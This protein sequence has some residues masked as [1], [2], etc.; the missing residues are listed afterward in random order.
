M[1]LK[2][3]GLLML[4]FKGEMVIMRIDEKFS[5]VFGNYWG[6]EGSI[7]ASVNAIGT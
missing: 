7:Y 3:E 5:I 2:S 4:F 1:M 6:L